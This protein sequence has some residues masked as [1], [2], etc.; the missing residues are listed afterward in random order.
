[1]SSVAVSPR[2][3][4]LLDE[5]L[6]EATSRLCAIPGVRGVIVGG[7]LGRD[8]PWPLS[9]IDVLPVYERST[10]PAGA[11]A[12]R[13]AELVDW[14]AAS[15][16]AQT[17]D[18]G[19]L[20][21]TADELR[22]A[23]AGGPALV[24]ERVAADARWSHGLN[25]AYGGRSGL[26][27]DGLIGEF[28][29]FA[30]EVRFAPVVVAARLG[31]WRRE[32]RRLAGEARSAAALDPAGA[33][34]SLRET[35][36]ALR[37]VLVEGWGERLGSMGREWTRFEAM[38]DRHGERR[39]ADLIARLAGADPAEAARRSQL[40]PH[41][42]RERI[43]LALAARLAVGEPVDEARNARDQ[44]AAFAVHVSRHRP[45]LHGAWTGSPDPALPQHLD[46]LAELVAELC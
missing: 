31:H 28:T 12:E 10:E 25:K 24:A 19:W 38:A 21:F 3:R 4:A 22:V 45:D 32:A 5:R 14:W 23:L 7:S 40:A 43:D 1:M 13:Q 11:V 39:R 33:T 46:E 41:W 18:L 26:P 6:A 27:E 36:R 37:L 16:R 44:L 15:G 9:D 20:A 30:T 34:V 8:E 35:A 29:A 2:W 42:L 17:L